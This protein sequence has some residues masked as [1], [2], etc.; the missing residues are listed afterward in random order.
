VAHFLDEV[1]A[2]QRIAAITESTEIRSE[3]FSERGVKELSIDN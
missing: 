1:L 2:Q 3:R